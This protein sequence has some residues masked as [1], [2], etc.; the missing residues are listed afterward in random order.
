MN[1]NEQIQIDPHNKSFNSLTDLKCRPA[2]ET[3]KRLGLDTTPPS[4]RFRSRYLTSPLFGG[5]WKPFETEKIDDKTVTN[6]G[7]RVHP[8]DKKMM[9]FCCACRT[10]PFPERHSTFSRRFC[11][12]E[13][14]FVRFEKGDTVDAL[15]VT[16]FEAPPPAYPPYPPPIVTEKL[17]VA[18]RA[19]MS[20][21]ELLSS[22]LGDA[23]AAAAA[24]AVAQILEV[25]VGTLCL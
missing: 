17:E 9:D 21:R 1:G 15:L 20:P 13:S 19:D 23:A 18:V 4:P 5:Q 14:A 7:N 25:A 12:L 11:G 16:E 6:S 22:S 8:K 2:S 10:K 3:E 24:P